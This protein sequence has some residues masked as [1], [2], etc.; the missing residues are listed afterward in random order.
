MESRAERFDAAIRDVTDRRGKEYGHP[1]DDFGRVALIKCAVK[2]CPVPEVRH[3]LEMIGVKLARLTETPDHLDS[4]IDIA[5]YARTIVMV[6]DE[7]E[8]RAKARFPFVEV[9][10]DEGGM[11]EKR[12][13]GG[14]PIEEQTFGPL[15]DGWIE[16]RG[17]VC[18][19]DPGAEVRVR[20]RGGRLDTGP[21]G[22]A[23]GALPR[24]W[25]HIGGYGDIVAYKVVSP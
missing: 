4:A 19:V 10:L 5:G 18:P 25:S 11:Y 21:A 6:L 9:G 3:A 22:V 7:R 1:L 24:R 12:R 17:G 2:D 8:A 23:G 16:W 15:E 14:D 13:L 20:L